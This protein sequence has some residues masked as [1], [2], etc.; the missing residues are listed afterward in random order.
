MLLW[1]QN[2]VETD[3][4]SETIVNRCLAYFERFESRDACGIVD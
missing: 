2:Q 4:P 3:E 1:P